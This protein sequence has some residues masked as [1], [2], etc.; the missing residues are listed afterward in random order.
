MAT[1]TKIGNHYVATTVM[2]QFS[3]ESYDKFCPDCDEEECCCEEMAQ[4]LIFQKKEKEREAR[5]KHRMKCRRY[6]NDELDEE[7]DSASELCDEIPVPKSFDGEGSDICKYDSAPE[8]YVEVPKSF[9]GELSGICKYDSVPESLD[10]E[11]SDI[12]EYD[13]APESYVAESI[14]DSAPEPCVEV[15]VPKSL[16]SELSDICE[17]GSAPTPYDEFCPD[18]DEEECC[19]EEMAQ[20]LI[21][22]EK[23][24]KREAR[25]KHR[26][27]CRRYYNDDFDFS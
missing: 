6:F 22:L 15:P 21:L 26:M 3:E 10:D 18:C 1:E 2:L 14:N 23:E 17:Y 24:R 11:W 8:S 13:S 9:D 5:K 7:Y 12:C 20:N 4:N 25:E 19:C 16:D 27:K